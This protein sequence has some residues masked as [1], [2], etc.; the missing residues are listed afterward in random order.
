MPPQHLSEGTKRDIR[1]RAGYLCEYC[2]TSEQW[3]S[4]PFTID[5][6]LP[7]SLGGSNDLE[8]LALA[9]F[10]CNRQKSNQIEALDPHSGKTVPIF[11]PRQEQWSE[12]FVWS[13]DKLYIVGRTSIG[14]AT[15]NA[16][17]LNR[18]RIVIIRSADLVVNRHP[19]KDDPVQS[20]E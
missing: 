2:H 19:P 11:N 10:T 1:Q 3:Q 13:A 12:H 7:V 5:H 6:I 16:L 8:N 18:D 14:R 15:V 4:V 17:I 20:P 9:C